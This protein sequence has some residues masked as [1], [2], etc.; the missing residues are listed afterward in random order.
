MFKSGTTNL[1]VE[2]VDKTVEFYEKMLGFQTVA[3]VPKENGAIQFAIVI[4]DNLTLMFQDRENLILEYPVLKTDK[5][6]PSVT[7]Y[8]KVDNLKELYIELKSKAKILCDIHETFYG[9][10]EFAIEDI[11]GYVLTFAEDK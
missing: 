3:S 7:I 8:I 1:M 2:S 5:V 4:R 6:R 10:N 9:A 11:N